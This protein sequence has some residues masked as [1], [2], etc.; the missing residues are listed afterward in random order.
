MQ[1]SLRLWSADASLP[2]RVSALAVLVIGAMGMSLNEMPA[3]EAGRLYM[4]ALGLYLIA[5]AAQMKKDKRGVRLLLRHK[6]YLCGA[7]SLT[8]A[9][10]LIAVQFAAR[11]I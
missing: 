3:F 4:I 6:R 7:L 11:L 8:V 1:R 5:P 9:L 10:S 2:L